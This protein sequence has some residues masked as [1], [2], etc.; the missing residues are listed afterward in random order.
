MSAKRY[1]LLLG[2]ATLLLLAAAAILNRIVD[3]FWVFRDVEIRGFNA[4]KPSFSK[5]ER[6]AKPLL[7]ARLRPQALIVGSSY[8]E[9][10]LPPTHVGFTDA[11]RLRPYN[12]AIAGAGWD[13]VYCYALLALQRAPVERMVLGVSGTEAHDCD[14]LARGFE[15]D[16]P[17][18]L[19]S[20]NALGASLE[21]LRRQDG[22][23]RITR[24]GLWY[25]FRYE[26]RFR[27]D[28]DI[29]R[30][31]ADEIQGRVCGAPRTRSRGEAIVRFAPGE[32]AGLRNLIR[33]AREK[34]AQLVLLVYPK[35]VFHY[36]LERRC[37]RLED[38]WNELRK[39]AA[40]VEELAST[41]ADAVQL[42]D[43]YG[44]REA[45]GERIR[46]GVAMAARHWQDSSHF[47][48]EFGALVFDAIFSERA[49]FGA[50]V[51][52]ADIARLAERAEAER[53]EFRERN[54]WLDQE[55]D[56]VLRLARRGADATR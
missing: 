9:V 56:G 20:K 38:H 39:L 35:H 1:T 25:F 3:P 42:W 51:R 11:G 32:D 5:N 7:V 8:A 26:N 44:Y 49:G 15:P 27:T 34:R 16:W 45:N 50:R 28:R 41:D 14:A 33:A 24:E 55:L 54:A 12:F 36:E 48:T 4:D 47:N 19:L 13:R 2:L 18:L 21:T 10:G 37:G 17:K 43:F 30:N 46:S 53:L 22:K 6:L 52:A 31:F 23:P 40:L 29:E